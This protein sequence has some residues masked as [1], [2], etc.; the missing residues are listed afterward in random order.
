MGLFDKIFKRNTPQ[1]NPIPP[2]EASGGSQLTLDNLLA[3]LTPNDAMALP[4]VFRCVQIISDAIASMP[5]Q[6]FEVEEDGGKTLAVNNNVYNL[7]RFSP[8][9]RMTKFDTVKQ[10]VVSMLLKGNGF[11]QIVR[12]KNGQPIELVYRRNNEV[13]VCKGGDGRLVRY[14]VNGVGSVEPID[15]IHLVRYSENGVD[16]VSV[17]SLA[18]QTLNISKAAEDAAYSFYDSGCNL[19]GII[20]MPKI[21]TRSQKQEILDEWANTFLSNGTR[22][23]VNLLPSGGTYQQIGVTAREAQLLEARNYNT[24]QVCQLFGVPASFLE[25]TGSISYN[26]LEMDTMRFLV[27]TLQPILQSLEEQ[28][29]AKL[30]LPSERGHY[31]VTFDTTN[32]LRTDSTTQ[33]SYFATLIQNGIMTVN[34]ARKR[35]NLPVLEGGDEIKQAA[36]QPSQNQDLTNE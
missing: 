4:A 8:S 9:P 28:F 7:L 12:N 20:S 36:Q 18:R 13:S 2:S 30:F 10:A 22:A 5:I 14:T 1:P 27:F 29:E 6:T 34:E 11:I 19:A 16:G 17:L 31:D 15:M 21:I 25:L 23:S 33:A 24:L 35:L 3:K 26:S 32:L